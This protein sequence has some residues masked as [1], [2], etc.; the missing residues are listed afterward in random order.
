MVKSTS[1]GGRIPIMSESFKKKVLANLEKNRTWGGSASTKKE[2]D[3]IAAKLKKDGYQTL[4]S[5]VADNVWV[6]EKSRV[7]FREM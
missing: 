6:V 5:K 4:V 1:K 2:A 7:N 3:E